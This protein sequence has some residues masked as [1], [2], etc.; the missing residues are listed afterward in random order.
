MRHDYQVEM[1]AVLEDMLRDDPP[2]QAEEIAGE[3]LWQKI[4]SASIPPA[5]PP[6]PEG[7]KRAE[8]PRSKR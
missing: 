3:A 4:R 1:I 5:L 6:A 7:T 8:T 2:S